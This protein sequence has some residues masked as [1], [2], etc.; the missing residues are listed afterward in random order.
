M[1]PKTAILDNILLDSYT[2][3][4]SISFAWKRKLIKGNGMKGRVGI[5]L[6]HSEWSRVEVHR[7]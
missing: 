6:L 7:D 3:W 5:I 1:L 4:Y 2:F